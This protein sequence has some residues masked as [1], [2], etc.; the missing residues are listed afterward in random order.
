MNVPLD[1]T[2]HHLAL[3]VWRQVSGRRTSFALYV[4]YELRAEGTV[5]GYTQYPVGT[6][7]G[8]GLA[9][10]PFV[11]RIDEV[12]LTKGVI[13]VDDFLRLEKRRSGMTVLF[14]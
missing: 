5:G 13:P 9:G 2:W 10:T 4:D 3:Q 8:F 12:R 7:W 1:G 6:H 14:R 11:G